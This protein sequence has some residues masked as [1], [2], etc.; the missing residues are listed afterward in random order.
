MK[1]LRR[2]GSVTAARAATR[3]SGEP[4]KDGA[5][6]RMERQVAPPSA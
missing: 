3:Y 6:V 4:W 2:T 1:S 5:S